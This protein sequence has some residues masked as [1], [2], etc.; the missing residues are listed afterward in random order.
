MDG[1]PHI[2]CTWTKKALQRFEELTPD[3]EILTVELIDLPD[4]EMEP[5]VIELLRE[6][7]GG[8]LMSVREQLL[9][10]EDIW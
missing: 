10:N 4:D 5:V 1:L 6:G 7:D 9:A 8:Q 2:D 3:V